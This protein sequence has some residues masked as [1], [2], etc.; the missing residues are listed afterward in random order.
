MEVV[1][2]P[3]ILY[4]R[5][6]LLL[7]IQKSDLKT[8]K[9]LL[10]QQAEMDKKYENWKKEVEKKSR[11]EREEMEK[12]KDEALKTS[13]SSRAWPK[14]VEAAGEIGSDFV[15]GVVESGKEVV[16]AIGNGWRAIK[17]WF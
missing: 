4:R 15:E 11:R 13:T 9:A 16:D 14:L 2:N 1:I 7:D 17:S 6:R 12:L 8:Q 5:N 3:H 10:E